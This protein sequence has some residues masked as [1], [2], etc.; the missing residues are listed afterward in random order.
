MKRFDIVDY[1]PTSRGPIDLVV[2]LQ[3]DGLEALPTIIAAPV[4]RGV[5]PGKQNMMEIAVRVQDGDCAL[6]NS[7]LA[8]LPKSV[9]GAVVGSASHLEWE[10]GRAL[11]RVLF[12]V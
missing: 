3:A 5:L 11:D 8:A 9:F 12:G 7:E 4:R 6:L 2:I 10:I 1:T